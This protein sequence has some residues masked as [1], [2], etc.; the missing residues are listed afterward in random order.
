LLR[1]LFVP[2]GELWRINHGWRRGPHVGFRLDPE[3]G[4]WQRQPDEP[5]GEEEDPDVPHA[6][7]N[8]KTYVTDKRNLL[9]IQS[10]TPAQD[11]VFPVTLMYAL[12]RAIEVTHQVEEQEISAELVGGSS[13]QR[14][15]L[16]EAAEGGTGVWERL[17]DEPSGIAELARQALGLCHYDQGTGLPDRA[18]NGDCVTGCYEC[19]LSY[20]N[21]N[22][23]R[24][25]D[26]RSVRDF[27]VRLGKASTEWEAKGRSP[28]E[29]FEWL[30]DKMDPA[31]TLAR[32]FIDFLYDNGYR[33]P[34]DAENRPAPD[35][36]VQPDF[37][38][39]R[40]GAPG[41]CIFVDGP[42]H[43]DPASRDRDASVRSAL[44][45]QG[46]RVVS[47]RYGT[48]FGSQVSSHPDIFGRP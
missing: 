29:Q 23:H 11:R 35:V 32:E 44:E 2:A 22:E 46:F 9:L 40:R 41:A 6:I 18:Y 38:Y 10:Q 26:R 12:R 19:L 48:E 28:S 37:Y 42:S 15:L 25:I 24:F 5:D 17:V 14:L 33:L 4:R 20:S 7:S 16:W 34:D 31:S 47:I 21:Q 27:L 39:E 1:L 8:I 13:E 43:N 36:G 45:N 30:L 3:S